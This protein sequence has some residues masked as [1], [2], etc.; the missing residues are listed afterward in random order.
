[1]PGEAKKPGTFSVT[2][3]IGLM[4]KHD[5]LYR[6]ATPNVWQG[7]QDSAARERYFQIVDCINA[8]DGLPEATKQPTFNLIGFASD[9]GVKRN[10]GRTGAAKGPSELRKH[11][12]NKALHQDS[13]ALNDCGDIVVVDDDLETAQLAYASLIAQ[14]IER[15]A[16]P[17]GLGGGHEIAWGTYQG[18][19]QA[20]PKSRLGIINFDAHF[21]MRPMDKNDKGSSGTPFR[22][23]AEH[24]QHHQLDFNY[25]VLGL[26]PSANTK[27]LY[28]TAQQY[29]VQTVNAEDFYE[30]DDAIIETIHQ[31]I[32]NCDLIYVTFCL[33]VMHASCAPGVS[34]PQ[35]C[36]LFP[37]HVLPL[38]KTI[39]NNA[40]VAAFDVAEL[41]PPLDNNDL[42]AAFAASIVQT[43]FDH[44][45]TR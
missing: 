5:K 29:H 25:L 31:F 15:S 18:L 33:D 43:A 28:E 41:A 40:N 35:A 37:E 8:R 21:D 2:P 39:F 45:Q 23:I 24:S 9:A 36:G 32:T 22:Q 16:I 3:V 14:S 30:R 20:Y 27:S 17:V 38:L 7:R 42:T 11:L 6:P 10:L 1:M 13:F 34:A 4:K 44:Y 19:R 26:Q 12:A